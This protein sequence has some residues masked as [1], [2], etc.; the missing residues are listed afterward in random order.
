M[1]VTGTN[2][3][4]GSASSTIQNT[5]NSDQNAVQNFL[6]YMKESPAEHMEDAWLSAHGLTRDDLK[7]MTPEKRNAI[8]KEMA[9][10]IKNKLLQQAQA[11]GKSAKSA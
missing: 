8:M 3:S 5:T 7:H 9:E 2:A 10:D 6:N 4:A 11:S 1:N